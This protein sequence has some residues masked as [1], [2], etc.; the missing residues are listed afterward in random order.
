MK[1]K[2][3]SLLLG[4]LL[5]FFVLSYC[6][7]MGEGRNEIPATQS[8]IRG[9]PVPEGSKLDE[10]SYF[11]DED[12]VEMAFYTHPYLTGEEVLLF[13]EREMPRWGWENDRSG[14]EHILQR[15]FSRDGVPVIIGVDKRDVGSS[16]SILK[17]VTGDWGYMAPLRPK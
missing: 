14:R 13:F 16:Y 1:I 8:V 15:Y 10:E 6:Y 17:G 2:R 4:A 11:K 9:L 12:G 5:L 3:E 7:L